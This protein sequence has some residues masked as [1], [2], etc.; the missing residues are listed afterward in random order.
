MPSSTS[1]LDWPEGF[2]RTDPSDRE[3][4]PHGFRVT[5]SQAF[6]NVLTELRR[7]DATN[8]QLDTGAQHQKTNPNKPYANASF[9]DPGVVVRFEVEGQQYAVPMDRWD[10][11]RDN[12]QAIAKTLEAKRALTRYG[13]ET[14]ESE[15]QTMALPSG[16]GEASQRRTGPIAVGPNGAGGLDEERAA[17]LLGVRVDADEDAIKGAAERK[18]RNGHPDQG[19]DADV[20]R[21]AEARDV[22]LE[23]DDAE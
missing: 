16:D 14:I 2:E 6:D 5:R 9:D 10:N 18:L 7:M 3:P 17:E 23:G 12:A 21:I 1:H 22:L 19:G 13:V 11:P 4:Y 20:A 15:Y 8:V